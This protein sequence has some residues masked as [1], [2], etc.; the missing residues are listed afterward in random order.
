MVLVV[1][2][3][4]QLGNAA[5]QHNGRVHA[6]AA[7]VKVAV[8][9][10]QIVAHL[11]FVAHFKRRGLGRAQHPQVGDIQLDLAG[12][13]RFVDALAPAQ[14]ALCHHH[15]FTFQPG[16]F[17][18]HRAVGAIVKCQLQNAGR[19]AQVGKDHPA[20]VAAFRNR[21]AGRYR[22]AHLFGGQLAAI[23]G[24]AQCP[25]FIHR[26]LSLFPARAAA[27]GCITTW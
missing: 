18:K 14:L 2:I 11:H 20:K 23:I 12:G 21:P 7:Q 27:Q 13:Q 3:A 24:A 6:G 4:H 9:E 10:A 26:S 22:A 25:H 16:G 15:I 1:V 19:V 5:T 8:F 17:F